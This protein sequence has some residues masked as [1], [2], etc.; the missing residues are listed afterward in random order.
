MANNLISWKTHEFEHR[1]K[2]SGWY[3][4]FVIIALMLIAY[5]LHNRDYFAALTFFI[6]SAVALMFAGIH[7]R[8]V[9]ITITDKGVNIENL[10]IP[11]V[12]IKKFWIVNHSKAKLL[13]LETTAYLNRFVIIQ[14]ADQDIEHIK[15]TL[16]KFLQEEHNS[17]ETMAQRLARTLRF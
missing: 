7:P 17:R 15:E 11:Y 2:G 16:G 10:H 12:N 4:T 5:A 8:E 13:Y 9:Q 14:L 6:I 1:E 3:L